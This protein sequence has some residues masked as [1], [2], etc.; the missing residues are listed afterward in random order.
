VT[1]PRINIKNR[2]RKKKGKDRVSIFGNRNTE[3]EAIKKVKKGRS[4]HGEKKVTGKS[5]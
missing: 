4:G 3:F 5:M 2:Q 1:I